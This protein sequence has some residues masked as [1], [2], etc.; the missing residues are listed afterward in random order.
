M[1]ANIHPLVSIGRIQRVEP[2][3]DP[4]G[5]VTPVEHADAGP[6]LVRHGDVPH[7]HNCSASVG[8]CFSDRWLLAMPAEYSH[9]VQ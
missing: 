3:V 1:I 2:V 9:C 6:V 5:A 8:G 7:C 4:S